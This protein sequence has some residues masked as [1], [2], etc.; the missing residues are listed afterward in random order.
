MEYTCF[1]TL[2]YF[3]LYSKVNQLYI[4]IYP[5]FFRFLSHLG[6]HRTLNTVSC[7]IQQ[8][9]ISYLFYIYLYIYVKGYPGDSDCKDSACNLENLGSIPGSGRYPGEGNDSSILA[10]RI[11]LKEPGGLQSMGS[12][13]VG[14]I[15]ATNTFTLS[16]MV[17]PMFQFIPPPLLPLVVINLFSISVTLLLLCK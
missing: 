2:C 15:W 8:I 6:H 17:L 14:Y 9:F 12:Q 1:T 4:Y 11:P 5:F 10:W 7:A 13:R 16:Y 3:L